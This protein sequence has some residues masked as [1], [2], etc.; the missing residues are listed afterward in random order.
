MKNNLE[1]RS[2]IRLCLLYICFLVPPPYFAHFPHGHCFN[3]FSNLTIQQQY[4]ISGTVTDSYGPMPGVHVLIKGTNIGTFTDN[5]GEYFLLVSNKD[6]LVFS[7]LGF[8][9]RELPVMGR[10]IMDVQ[11]Q[12]EVT[13][14]QEVEVNAGYYTVKEKERTGSISRVTAAEIELQPIVSPLEALQGRMA[15]VEVVQQNGVPGSAPIIRIRGQNSLRREGNY[16]LYIIDGVPIIST[17]ITGGSNM[18]S[19]GIDPLSTLNLSNI[20]SIEVLKDADATAIY[21]SRGANGVVLITT[22]K[23][24]GYD[25][26][27]VVEARWYSGLGTVSNKMELLDTQQYLSIRRT[28][29][30]NDGREANET[31][32]YDLLLW[33][34]NRYTDW[35]EELFGG[36]STITDVNISASGGNATTSFRLG[37]SYHREDMVFPGDQDYNKITGGLNLNH[38]SENKKFGLDLAINYGKDISGVMANS[39]NFIRTAFSLPPN[40]PSL[41]ND[42]G[43][44]HWDEWTYSAWDNPIAGIV[45][46]K[47]MDEGYNLLANLGL[48][49][50]LFSDL[51]FK[52]NTGYT[53]LDREYRAFLSKDQYNPEAQE[54][55]E[56]SSIATQRDRKSWILEPQ[57]V[58]TKKVGNGTIDGLLGATF[59]QS[60]NMTLSILGTGYISES[61]LGDLS[62]AESANVDI[63]EITEYKYNALFARLGYNYQ[64]KYFLNLTGRRDGSSR[65]GPNK[66]FANFWAVGGAWI[67]SEEMAVQHQRSFLSFGKLRA[68]YGTT[69]NDQ[70]ADYG[71]LDAYEATPGPNGLYPTQ[72]TNPD[73]SWEENKKLEVATELGFIKDRIHLALGWYRNRSSNQLVGYPLPATTGFNTVQANLPATVENRGWELELSTVNLRDKELIWQTTFNIS[74]PQNKLIRYPDIDQSSYANRY[75]VGHPLNI[76]LLYQYNGVDP[77]TGLYSVVDVNGDERYD[78]EDRKVIKHLGRQYFGG[79]GNNLSYKELS[80]SFLCEFVKQNGYPN[81]MGLPGQKNVQTAAFYNN[82]QNGNNPDIQNVSESYNASLA[83]DLFYQSGQ[84]LTDASYIRLK[85]VSLS[86]DLPNRPLKKIGLNGCKIFVQAQNLLTITGYKGLNVAFPGGNS[87]PSLRTITIGAQ[88]NL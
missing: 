74:F 77:E 54:S 46:R 73:Y 62:A 78:Y 45:H 2:V 3:S 20:Q 41:Y 80:F 22:K 38:L 76:G 27:T 75:R 33:D 42:D 53:H 63:D 85:T 83:Y 52:L 15:G 8:H 12:S 71:Y 65:F 36:T 35:Q 84:S 32:D 60:K 43:S 66:R 14:L 87:I 72:L 55:A 16:P 9:T 13:E 56:H 69:G 57:L 29:L 37:G 47:A 59:Q 11:M 34:Q 30:E 6:I 10:T 82:W 44:V 68:S 21:G 24:T 39:S 1:Y 86:Y 61:L 40:A 88:F 48:S 70:I 28:A 58:Y 31:S 64:R 17:P 26:K 4:Q 79:V 50:Q 18:Y 5:E 49:Y 7:Y 81:Y 19:D 51:T 25:K 67:F 23:G